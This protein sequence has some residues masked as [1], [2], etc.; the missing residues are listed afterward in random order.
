M[1]YELIIM[2][3]LT[4]VVVGTLAYDRKQTDVDVVTMRFDDGEPAFK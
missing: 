3:I 2:L 4:M 1:H